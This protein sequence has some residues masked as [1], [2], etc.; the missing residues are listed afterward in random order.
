MFISSFKSEA[1]AFSQVPANSLKP[2]K[3]PPVVNPKDI[4]LRLAINRIT[5]I[6]YPLTVLLASRD[7]LERCKSSDCNTVLMFTPCDTGGNITK[8]NLAD[9]FLLLI[10]D[11]CEALY[12]QISLHSNYRRS[13]SKRGGTLMWDTY[14]A[15]RMV[16]EDYT[17]LL[18]VFGY[19][20][21]LSVLPADAIISP[22]VGNERG[23]YGELKELWNTED[24]INKLMEIF[25]DMDASAGTV[26]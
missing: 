20:Y 21:N 25:R 10:K 8:F 24:K 19:N 15:L 7:P 26:H 22:I 6:R 2:A 5:E 14:Y 13:F 11:V 18:N 17:M 4:S 9:A 16:Y 3:R 12:S 1:Q 23:E